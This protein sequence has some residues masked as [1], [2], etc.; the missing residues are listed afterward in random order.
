M[1]MFDRLV[2]RPTPTI[3]CLPCL[4]SIFRIYRKAN[5]P[6]QNNYITP[7]KPASHRPYTP[8]QKREHTTHKFG[9]DKPEACE[10]S[11]KVPV[12]VREVGDKVADCDIHTNLSTNATD[13][14]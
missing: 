2:V 13:L 14:S 11:A 5:I 4:Y 6:L 1:D 10:S 9:D 12:S 8:A 3:L 7:A